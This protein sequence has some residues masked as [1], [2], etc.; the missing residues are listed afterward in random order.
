ML[1]EFGGDEI[2]VYLCLA[3]LDRKTGDAYL[4][5]LWMI[6]INDVAIFSHLDLINSFNRGVY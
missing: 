2:V 1:A 5:H 4:A 3:E 6:E